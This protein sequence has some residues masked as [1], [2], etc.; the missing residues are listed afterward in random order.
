M[1][2][3]TKSQYGLAVAIANVQQ[4]LINL[5]RNLLRVRDTYL[6]SD[7]VDLDFLESEADFR[8]VVE[9][10]GVLITSI[11]DAANPADSA[12]RVFAAQ[13]S[14]FYFLLRLKGLPEEIWPD[15]APPVVWDAR[16]QS[17][18]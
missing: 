12:G 18:K 3:A 13:R 17:A 10:A 6:P 8:G 11:E 5:A 9:A 4:Q 16:R 15:L 7:W 2:E 1:V 14:L